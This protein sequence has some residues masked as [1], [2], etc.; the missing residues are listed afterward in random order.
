MI[1]GSNNGGIDGIFDE[2]P[3][4][5]ILL[6]RY[7][8][9]Y[10]I[11]GPQYRTDGLGF[12][13]PVGSPL[14]AHF[15]RAILNVTQGPEMTALEQKSFGPGYS[16]QDPLSDTVSQGASSLTAL[17]F[18]GLFI[19]LAV[20]TTIALVYV[21]R[22]NLI[23]WGSAFLNTLRAYINRNHAPVANVENPPNGAVAGDGIAED[24]GV[25]N[26]EVKREEM[27]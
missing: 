15:S 16:S 10:K 24:D 11:V 21:E 13:L 25:N 4:M 8:N 27:M 23:S 1:N 22:G 20:F 14:V 2:L 6:N 26:D 9:Q 18:A 5:K 7:G 19:L 17:D 12:A 3:Y